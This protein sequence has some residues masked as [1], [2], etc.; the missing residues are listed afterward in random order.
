MKALLKQPDTG[1]YF[2]SRK[3]WTPDPKAAHDFKSSITAQNYCQS[4]GILNV[5]IVLKFNVDKYDIVLSTQ[6][7][8]K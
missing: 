5:Q 1:L 3:H 6:Y 8:R 7:P 4:K 2:K